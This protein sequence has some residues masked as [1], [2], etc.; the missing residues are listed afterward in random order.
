[1]AKKKTEKQQALAEIEKLHNT[2]TK[3]HKAHE[4]LG[5]DLKEVKKK[6]SMMKFPH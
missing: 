6:I 3:L 2:H 5:L 4:K 1:M